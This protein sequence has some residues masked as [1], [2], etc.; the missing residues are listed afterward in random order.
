VVHYERQR[1]FEV[2]DLKKS[3]RHTFTSLLNEA[4]NVLNDLLQDGLI[5]KA[6]SKLAFAHLSFQEYLAA[7]DLF[8]PTGQK[9]TQALKWFLSGDDWWREVLGFYVGLSTKPREIEDWVFNSAKSLG[10]TQ[11]TGTFDQPISFLLKLLETYFPGFR[12]RHP[13]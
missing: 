10:R 6:G 3:I 13:A 2:S 8:D 9:V 5:T 4:E 7:K 12:T 11:A 1:D